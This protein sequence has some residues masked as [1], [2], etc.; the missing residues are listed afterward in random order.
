MRLPTCV[1]DQLF[2]LGTCFCCVRLSMTLPFAPLSYHYVC[3]PRSYGMVLFTEARSLPWRQTKAPSPSTRSWQR[4]PPRSANLSNR[5]AWPAALMVNEQV[6]DLMK[7]VIY[8]RLAAA[9][10]PNWALHCLLATAQ[11]MSGAVHLVCSARL[12]SPLN[13]VIP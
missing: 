2:C 8:V 6:Q 7:Q 10:I 13:V 5:R 1:P 3:L 11:A 4:Y 9:S 12:C